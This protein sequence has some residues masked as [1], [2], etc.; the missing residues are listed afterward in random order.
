MAKTQNRNPFKSTFFE[1]RK[2]ELCFTNSVVLKIIER[3]NK[4]ETKNGYHIQKIYI[5]QL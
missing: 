5:T 1:N 3:S 4:N 2:S